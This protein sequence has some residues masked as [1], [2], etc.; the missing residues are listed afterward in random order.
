MEKIISAELSFLSIGSEKYLEDIEIV[1]N[2]IKAT[3]LEYKIGVISTSVIG[4]KSE[5]LKL[6]NKIVDEMV[7]ICGF[8]FDIKLS[9]LCGCNIE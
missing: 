4:E 1:L 3:N 8:R 7:E 6:I 2:I 5:V 9:N